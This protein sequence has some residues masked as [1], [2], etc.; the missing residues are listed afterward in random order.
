MRESFQRA[1][2]QLQST[3]RATNYEWRFASCFHAAGE[4]H[5]CFA[6][7]QTLRGLR[8]G[9]NA[10]AAQ[11][12]YGYGRSLHLQSGFQPY[13]ARAVKRV[14]AGLHHIAENRM[15]DFGGI[16]ARAANRFLRSVRGKIN[17]RNI[18]KRAGITRH[19]RARPGNNYHIGGKHNF[20]LLFL[21]LELGAFQCDDRV[22]AAFCALL[23]RW[24]RR[25]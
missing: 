1:A 9:L 23:R 11:A 8:N 12:I 4:N 6:E 16:G 20:P 21:Q 10:G 25:D 17:R 15:I 24:F 7:Q 18:G 13:V 19:G 22:A 2:A 14:S 3:A 5:F